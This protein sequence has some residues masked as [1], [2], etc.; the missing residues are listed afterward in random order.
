MPED[1]PGRRL[2]LYPE[3]LRARIDDI[4]PWLQSDFNTGVYKAG[5]ATDQE[6]YERNVPPVFAALN[7]LEQLLHRGGGP[8]LLGSELTELDILAYATAIRFDVVYV[9]HFKVN[10]E[11]LASGC[12]TWQSYLRWTLELG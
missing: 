12:W 9:Q 4:S 6:T 7:Q 11:Y 1:S 5:F 10:R 3:H 8:Y 2:D